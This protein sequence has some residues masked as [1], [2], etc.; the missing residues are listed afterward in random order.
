MTNLSMN[1]NYSNNDIKIQNQLEIKKHSL[2]H[3]YH[4]R[5][6]KE[7]KNLGETLLIE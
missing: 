7:Q 1:S 5:Q 6:F 2:A 3:I 4:F